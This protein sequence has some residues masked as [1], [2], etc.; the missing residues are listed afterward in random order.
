[1][2]KTRSFVL[3]L[4]ACVLLFALAACS[5]EDPSP[6]D[7]VNEGEGAPSAQPL[8]EVK[9]FF[10]LSEQAPALAPAPDSAS[11]T[12]AE[13]EAFSWCGTAYQSAL[14]GSKMTSAPSAA[15]SDI[16]SVMSDEMDRYYRFYLDGGMTLDQFS[17]LME[18]FSL[19]SG[20]KG[21]ALGYLD[22][23]KLETVTQ[24]LEKAKEWVEKGNFLDASLCLAKVEKVAENGTAQALIR[25]HKD[26]FQKGITDA[27][28]EFMVRWDIDEGK[29]FLNSLSGL[30]V[31]AHLQTEANRLEAYRA[32]QE[33]DLVQ[34]YV[35]STLENLYSHCL[36][37][38]PEVNFASSGTYRYCGDDC[39]TVSEFKAILN[40]LYE[41]GYIIVDA[42]LF[43]DQEKDAP[44]TVLKLPKGKKPLL[45]T[46]DDV[47]YDSRKDN[48]GMVD[49]LILDESGRVCTW[50]RHE[51]GKEEIS[52]DNEIFPVINAFVREHPDFT[53]QGG[54]GTLFF[55]GFDGICG[56]R[57]QSEPIDDKEAALG[58]DR[59]AEVRAVKPVIEAMREEGWTFGSHS[60]AHGRMP[61]FS[62]ERIRRDTNQW[63]EE[64]G[65]IVGK[66]GLFCWPYGGHTAGAVSLRKN[67]D[68]KFLFDSGFNF[69]FGC[70]AGRYLADELDGNGI[71]SDRKAITGEILYFYKMGWKTYVREYSYLFDP[72]AIWDEMRKPYQNMAPYDATKDQ[73]LVS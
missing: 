9:A 47:T 25:D 72:N 51:D 59:Q 13:K 62:S 26:A 12:G 63:L 49:K 56:Y 39:L 19:H 7:A 10:A 29:A 43:Y 14:K 37:A 45:L 5:S 71:F 53:F 33:D 46:F 42:N 2:K 65:A 17:F 38:F 64:V 15:W 20:A 1:M 69:F 28:T 11:F 23:A 32:S 6:T 44:V 22:S 70:G 60:Y 48:R 55:T 21:I 41:K 31:N 73:N 4:L 3:L 16:Y 18:S 34:C 52:Y 61:N 54:R 66:T 30:G 68:H 57:S 8:E 67:E 40:A 24:P 36:I 27:V 35:L 58:L 50:T